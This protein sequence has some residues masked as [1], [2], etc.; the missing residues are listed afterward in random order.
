MVSLV[1]FSERL[2][3]FF[4]SPFQFS[5]IA[6]K[7]DSLLE[8]VTTIRQSIFPNTA[9]AQAILGVQALHRRFSKFLG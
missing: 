6:F 4:I 7:K 9:T 2:F 1:W 3:R 8:K 5:K